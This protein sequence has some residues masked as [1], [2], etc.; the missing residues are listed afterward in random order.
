MDDL[1]EIL[2]LKVCNLVF[3]LPKYCKL[4]QWREKLAGNFVSL[5]WFSEI[6]LTLS[7][8]KSVSCVISSRLL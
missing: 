6:D 8:P 4:G 7:S 5:L 2:K 3:E 1:L